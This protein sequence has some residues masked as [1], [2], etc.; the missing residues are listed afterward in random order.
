M[1]RHI[2]WIVGHS[3]RILEIGA[4]SQRV[5]RINLRIT[6]LCKQR[7]QMG[8]IMSLTV[9]ARVSLLLLLVL[10]E[11]RSFLHVFLDSQ[12]LVLGRFILYGI[13]DI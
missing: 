9:V 4:M 10:Y 2:R 7:I 5:R 13:E 12:L 6:A 1:G 3:N 8:P 11:V